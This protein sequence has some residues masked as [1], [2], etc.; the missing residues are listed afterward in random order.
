MNMYYDHNCNMYKPE[1]YHLTLFRA[2]D[3]MEDEIFLGLFKELQSS[4]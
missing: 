2:Q 4:F 1:T 3:L